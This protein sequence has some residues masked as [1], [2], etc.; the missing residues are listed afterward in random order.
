MA[1]FPFFDT[2]IGYGIITGIVIVAVLIYTIYN[3]RKQVKR[4]QKKE[5]DKGKNNL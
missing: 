4:A 3:L 1:F 2:A 5:D